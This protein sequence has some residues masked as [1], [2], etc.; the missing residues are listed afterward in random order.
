MKLEINLFAKFAERAGGSTITLS[1]SHELDQVSVQQVKTELANLWPDL[2]TLIEQSFI[3]KNMEYAHLEELLTEK[4]EIAIIAPVSGGENPTT[5]NAVIYK[6]EENLYQL[7]Q[8]EIDP[9]EVLRQVIDP[10]HGASIIFVGTTRE[11]T[12]GMRTTLLEYEAYEPMALKTMEQIGAEIS[13]RWPGTKTAITHRLGKVEIAEKSIVIA[14]SAP[15]RDD[16]YAAS[17]YAIE[18]VK[19]IVPIWKKEVWADGSEW[20]GHQTGPWNPLHRK[21]R[22][23][24]NP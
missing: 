23:D 5:P 2:S 1:F 13:R 8:K 17:R 12:Q 7:T 15:H 3:A 6:E 9:N 10:N 4:D 20:K 21:E 11:W 22:S 19:E 18:R 16:S 24:V 14:V